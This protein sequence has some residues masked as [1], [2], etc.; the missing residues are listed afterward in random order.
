MVLVLMFVFGIIAVVLPLVMLTRLGKVG[1]RTVHGITI[2]SFVAGAIAMWLPFFDVNQRANLAG[3]WSGIMDTVPSFI[4]I[5]GLI[6]LATLILN[7]VLLFKYSRA[8]K[9]TSLGGG[10]ALT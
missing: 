7:L 2:A 6:L 5:G 8:M 1:F 3:D 4:L 10:A 9:F